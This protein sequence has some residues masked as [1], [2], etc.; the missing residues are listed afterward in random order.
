MSTVVS[1]YGD[2]LEPNPIND[3]VGDGMNGNGM[4][5]GTNSSNLQSQILQSQLMGQHQNNQG[6]SSFYFGDYQHF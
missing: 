6:N 1:G 3:V 5:S 4:S 2:I